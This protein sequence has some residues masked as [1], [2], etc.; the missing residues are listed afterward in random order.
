MQ[1]EFNKWLVKYY[2]INGVPQNLET[3]QS[4]SL[5]IQEEVYKAYLQTKSI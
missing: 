3:L 5:L 4:K 2:T 1:E